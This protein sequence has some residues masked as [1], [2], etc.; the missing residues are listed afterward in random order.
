M[1]VIKLIL[2]YNKPK[3]WLPKVASTLVQYLQVSLEAAKVEP[4]MG[5]HFKGKLLALSANI[6]LGWKWLT[7]S[8]SQMLGQI[9]TLDLFIKHSL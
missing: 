2:D 1:A 5:L 6:R 9:G 7:D 4:L 8:L 3:C